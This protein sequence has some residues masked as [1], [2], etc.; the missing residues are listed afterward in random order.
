MRRHTKRANAFEFARLFSEKYEEI[1]EYGVVDLYCAC[2]GIDDYA[3]C[4]KI[5]PKGMLFINEFVFEGCGGSYWGFYEQ[6]LAFYRDGNL[7]G[8]CPEVVWKLDCDYDEKEDELRVLIDNNR[9]DDYED[10]YDDPF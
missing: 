6:L 7:I 4:K 10:E 3:E 9:A 8:F 5:L 1:D 2:V